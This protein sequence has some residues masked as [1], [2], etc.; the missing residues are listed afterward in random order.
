MPVNRTS[1][2]AG[3]FASL[4]THLG[5]GEEYEEIRRR[6]IAFF[7]W[8]QFEDPDALADEAL[9]RLA[10]KLNEGAAIDSLRSY[11]GGIARLLAKE[12][13]GLLKRERAGALEF[14]RTLPDSSEQ[15]SQELASTDLEN[16]LSSL[17]SEQRSLLLRYYGGAPKT[18]IPDRKTMAEEL[19]LEVNAL[20]NRLLRLR[21]TLLECMIRR[22]ALRDDRV[23]LPTIR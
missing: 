3:A 9:D 1:D 5:S 18:R 17:N 22:A 8:E 2:G 13:R 19:G 4:L 12:Q 14:R 20:R 7:R 21:K 23:N 6:L 10:R 11:A 15:H 16:C